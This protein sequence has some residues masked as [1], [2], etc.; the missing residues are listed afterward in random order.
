MSDYESESDG[1]VGSLVNFVVDGDGDVALAAATREPMSTREEAKQLVAEFPY[2]R[3][4]LASSSRPRRARKAPERYVDKDYRRLMFEADDV[5]MNEVMQDSSSEHSEDYASDGGSYH[6]EGRQ[7]EQ[8]SDEEI[9]EEE[10]TGVELRGGTEPDTTHIRGFA[11]DNDMTQRGAR[12]Q[13]KQ[14]IEEFEAVNGRST[15]L[16]RLYNSFK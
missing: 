4:L 8:E 2:D 12:Q 6:I 1:S 11:R 3:K 14:L 9:E 13:L 16:R 5:D 10:E 15:P 7:E